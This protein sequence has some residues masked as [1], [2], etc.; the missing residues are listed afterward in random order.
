MLGSIAVLTMIVGG[1]YLY[2]KKN[3]IEAEVW[4]IFFSTLWALIIYATVI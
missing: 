2:K 1:V 3:Y 4:I